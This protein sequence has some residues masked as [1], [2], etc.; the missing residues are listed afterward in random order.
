MIHL[1]PV[2]RHT[3]LF[4][5]LRKLWKVHRHRSEQKMLAQSMAIDTLL[6]Q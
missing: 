4:I 2:G 3:Q 5:N 1:I 6:L